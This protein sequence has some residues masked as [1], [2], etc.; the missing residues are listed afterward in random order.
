MRVVGQATAIGISAGGISAHQLNELKAR[1]QH[2]QTKLQAAQTTPSNATAL[3]ANLT[4]EQISGDLLT[5][6]LWSWFAAAESHNR[7]EVY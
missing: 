5:A 1:L 6:T 3:L 4:G 7:W 2:T